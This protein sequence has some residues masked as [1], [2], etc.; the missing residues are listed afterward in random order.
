MGTT[1]LLSGLERKYAHLTGEL[2]AKQDEIVRIEKLV[3]TIP[4][5]RAR[6]A[7]LGALA[8]HA[9]ALLKHLKPGWEQQTVAPVRPF[10]HQLPIKLGECGRK[11]LEVLRMAN[12][13]MTAREIANE[14]LRRAGIFNSDSETSQRASNAVLNALRFR[15]GTSVESDGHYPQRWRVKLTPA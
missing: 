8:E 3:E 13:P 14:V 15:K 6:V 12:E 7:E 1:N 9:A 10:V 4:A 11:G 2:V 5:L